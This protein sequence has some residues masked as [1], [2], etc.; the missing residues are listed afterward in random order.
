MPPPN[1]EYRFRLLSVYP[2]IK[3]Y[4]D[5]ILYFTCHSKMMLNVVI[6]LRR[7]FGPKKLEVAEYRKAA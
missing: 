2:I 4:L 3:T 6:I 7:I 5:N 1:S